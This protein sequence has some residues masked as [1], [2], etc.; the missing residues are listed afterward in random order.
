MKYVKNV[1]STSA[2]FYVYGEIVDEKVPDFWT[3][4][5][6]ST[7]V[8][9]NELRAD[10]E[11][12]E[13]QGITDFNI[14]INSPGGSV[15]A[16]SAIM[17][18]IKRFKQKTGARIHSY[19]DGIAASAASF[20]ALVA[21][22]VNVYNTSIFMIHKPL[23]FSYGNAD[24]LQ[25]DIDLLNSIED[26]TI[27]P[28]YMSKATV[29]EDTIKSLVDEETWFNGNPEDDLYMGNFFEINHLDEA[30]AVT[31][32]ASKNLFKMYKHLPNALK[33]IKNEAED[34]EKPVEKQEESQEEP[35]EKNEVDKT[36]NVDYSQ[37][38][39]TIKLLQL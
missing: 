20:L 9:P 39:A 32:C 15:F 6:S 17:S 8:D 5:I 37:F 33:N 36:E 22:D 27:V 16:A 34:V 2:D 12:L 1:T 18:Q 25:R 31:A 26:N 3:G 10:L 28:A 13:K 7:E 30:K 35:V 19:I 24:D 21:D 14:Y 23:V 4:D 38:D 11:E 29:D